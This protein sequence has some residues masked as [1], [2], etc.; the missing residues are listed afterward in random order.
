MDEAVFRELF[1]KL[2]SNGDSEFSTEEIKATLGP[3]ADD[4]LAK[5]LHIFD[6]DNSGTFNFEE[7]MYFVAAMADGFSRLCIK[8]RR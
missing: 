1:N 4:F 5:Y 2:D 8:V 6:T 7:N 3:N